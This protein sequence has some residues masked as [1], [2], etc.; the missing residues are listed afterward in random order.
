M[1]NI[2]EEGDFYSIGLNE[3]EFII[4]SYQ[5]MYNSITQLNLWDFMKQDPP[6]NT[7]YLFWNVPEVKSI[8]N[9]VY[10]DGHSGSSFALCMRTMQYIAKY[11]WEKYVKQKET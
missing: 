2:P 7:G 10:S 3:D 6:S 9:A 8:S 5:N 11:G 4:E 1:D